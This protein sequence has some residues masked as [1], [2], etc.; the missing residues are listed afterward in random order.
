MATLGEIEE[1]VE[2]VQSKGNN[3]LCLLK[4]SSAY[5]AIPDDMNLIT[6]RHLEKIFGVPVGLSDHS[7]GSIAAVTAVAMGAKIIEKHFCISR[8][9]ENP[10]ASFSMEPH[11]FKKMV[12]DI[13]DAERAIGKESYAIS[14][15]EGHS[16]VFR[17]SIFVVKDIKK[18][19][20]FTE[21]NIRV[22][23]PGYGLAPKYYEN[24]LGKRAVADVERGTPLEW[25]MI[26]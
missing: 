20:A 16:R 3:Q 8:K 13:R 17:R 1:A 18:G 11:E 24:I 9:I 23:R 7:L 5:P 4:C 21:E 14:E 19:E 2:A 12:K 22:I 26:G 15:R 25:S 6:I 10:D